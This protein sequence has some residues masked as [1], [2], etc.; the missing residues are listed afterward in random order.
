MFSVFSVSH[1]FSVVF[2]S[3]CW[4]LFPQHDVW[5]NHLEEDDLDSSFIRDK[6]PFYRP[7]RPGAQY[8]AQAGLDLTANPLPQLPAKSQV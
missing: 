3:W 7:G 5:E 8:L 4:P 1:R 2:S 6:V